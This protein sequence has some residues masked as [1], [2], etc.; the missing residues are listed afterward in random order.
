MS[1]QIRIHL[2]KGSNSVVAVT[3]ENNENL[4][5]FL[6]SNSVLIDSECGGNGTCGKCRV[7]IIKRGVPEYVLACQYSISC[8][9]DVF[10]QE[11]SKRAKIIVEGRGLNS[12]ADIREKP[13]TGGKANEFGFAVDIG[14]TTLA[15]YFY[16]LS[17]KERVDARA[18]LNPSVY[19]AQTL[20][21]ELLSKQI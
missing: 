17:T 9:L 3:A 12:L 2:G 5:E 13:T 4:L 8:D 21:Q 19:T 1:H 14:T 10:P 11:V 20:F 15:V 16:N 6:R 7:R 18:E